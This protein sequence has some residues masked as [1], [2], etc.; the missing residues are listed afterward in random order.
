MKEAFKI[1]EIDPMVSNGEDF[2][3]VL[4]FD[5]H[6]QELNISS[7]M[8]AFGETKIHYAF[9]IFFIVGIAASVAVLV[10]VATDFRNKQKNIKTTIKTTIQTLIEGK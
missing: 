2:T 3:N 5:N 1:D 9:I 10:F 6:A 4:D 8:R 7:E